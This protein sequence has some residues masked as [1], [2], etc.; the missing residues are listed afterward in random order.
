[1][2]R[3]SLLITLLSVMFTFNTQATIVNFD[4]SNISPFGGPGQSSVADSGSVTNLSGGSGLDITGNWWAAVT[5]SFEVINS[6]YLIFDFTTR[7]IG[8]I[9]GIGFASSGE[10]SPAAI[11]FTTFQLLGYQEWG[12]Q[13]FRIDASNVTLNQTYSFSINVGSFFTGTFDR[14][15]FV[16]DDDGNVGQANGSAN[17]QFSNVSVVSA[18]SALGIMLLSFGLILLRTRK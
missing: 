13:D 2:L 12:I 1:M 15:V 9:H 17:S 6:T 16:M 8:E 18:P 3:K 11:E 10:N 4:L 5:E 7:D 14:I